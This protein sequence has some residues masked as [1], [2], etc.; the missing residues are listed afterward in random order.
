MIDIESL[1]AEAKENE[2]KTLY[3][4]YKATGSRESAWDTMT[5]LHGGSARA[6]VVGKTITLT[7]VDGTTSTYTEA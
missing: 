1:T 3:E 5:L 4:S 7:Y 6:V 2:P